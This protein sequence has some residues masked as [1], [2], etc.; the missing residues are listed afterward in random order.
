MIYKI[1]GEKS[2]AG[3]DQPISLHGQVIDDRWRD[4]KPL[5]R[6]DSHRRGW[7]PDKIK[8]SS[9]IIEFSYLTYL[10]SRNAGIRV[11]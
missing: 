1:I 6:Y 11:S 10:K 5:M 9:I 7:V 2:S 8:N 4:N 3:I